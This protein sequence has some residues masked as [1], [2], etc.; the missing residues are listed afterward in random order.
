MGIWGSGPFDSDTASGVKVDVVSFLMKII[1]KDL[2]DAS[3]KSGSACLERPTIAAV[4]LLSTLLSSTKPGEW[5]LVT[6]NKVKAWEAA[7]FAWFEK[8]FAPDGNDDFNK[9]CRREAKKQFRKLLKCSYNGPD[10]DDL[11]KEISYSE[12]IK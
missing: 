1:E 6:G 7:Y 8:Y 9:E 5:V 12:R 3:T 4:S 2:K 10:A 11:D